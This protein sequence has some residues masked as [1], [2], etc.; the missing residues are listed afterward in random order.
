VRLALLAAV[1]L[2]LAATGC[3]AKHDVIFELQ[4][5]LGPAVPP[6]TA[7]SLAVR[8]TRTDGADYATTVNR[9]WPAGEPDYTVQLLLGETA[10]A[11]DATVTLLSSNGFPVAR[12]D[13]AQT[14]PGPGRY[15]FGL[16]INDPLPPASDAGGSDAGGTD[17]GAADAGDGG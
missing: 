7:L 13:A 15:F 1:S 5:S 4:V 8:V 16:T 3:P 11:I 14:F 9:A 12:A 10:S 6:P 2:A 17:A